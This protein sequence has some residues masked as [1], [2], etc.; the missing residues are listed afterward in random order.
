MRASQDMLG[1]KEGQLK[2]TGAKTAHLR[3]R[4][5]LEVFKWPVNLIIH[6]KK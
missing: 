5:H 6:R 2:E 4:L 3:Q 1:S